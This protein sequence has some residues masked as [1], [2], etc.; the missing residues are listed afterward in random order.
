MPDPYL[1]GHARPLLARIDGT[2]RPATLQG[3]QRHAAGWIAHVRYRTGEPIFSSLFA[4]LAAVD[5][6][7]A[8]ACDECPAARRAFVERVVGGA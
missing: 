6:R 8:T 4:T 3:W 2:W 7:D 1:P 5:V